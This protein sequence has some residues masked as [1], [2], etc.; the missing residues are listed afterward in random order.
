MAHRRIDRG[1]AVA[2]TGEACLLHRGDRLAQLLGEIP[3]SWHGAHLLHQGGPLP[4]DDRG[5]FL[6][7]PG[8]TYRP[9]MITE[10]PLE[11]AGDGRYG[12]TDE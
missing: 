12:E 3:R 9:T 8:R 2:L 7:R 10:M 11:H 4:P 5:E 6:S 1:G